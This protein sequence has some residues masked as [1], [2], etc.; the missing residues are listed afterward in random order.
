MVFGGL[1]W[2]IALAGV[3]LSSNE[4][5]SACVGS[6]ITCRC[7]WPETAIGRCRETVR[8]DGQLRSTLWP[9]RGLVCHCKLSPPCHGDE[10]ITEL[11]R[12]T[13][14][15]TTF[16]NGSERFG[17]MMRRGSKRKRIVGGRRGTAERIRME[18]AG[19]PH[20]GR[21]HVNECL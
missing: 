6:S 9:L 2:W 14:R 8:T 21:L 10:I 19:R 4:C 3:D 17:T 11:K 18:R 1:C 15:R 7:V 5:V 16:L 20:G 13:E 12:K